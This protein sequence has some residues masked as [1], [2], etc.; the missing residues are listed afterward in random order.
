MVKKNRS[1]NFRRNCF[2][3]PRCTIGRSKW[4]SCIS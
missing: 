3:N 2:S 1:K 4:N